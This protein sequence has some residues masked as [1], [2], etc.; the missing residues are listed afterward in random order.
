MNVPVIYYSAHRPEVRPESQW[1]VALLRHLLTHPEHGPLQRWNF[2]EFIEGPRQCGTVG[3]IVV[4]SGQHHHA[5]ADVAQLRLDLSNMKWAIVIIAGDECSLFPADAFDAL[6]HVVEWRM[7]PRTDI[8]YRPG[9]RFLEEGWPTG[10]MERLAV[11][12]RDEGEDRDLD[13]F[14]SGQ[15]THERRRELVLALESIVASEDYSIGGVEHYSTPGF[16]RGM[17]R[18][19]YLDHLLTTKIAPCPSGVCT[20]DSFRLYEAL[21]AGCLPVVETARPNGAADRDYWNKMLG[22][23]PDH[24]PFPGVDS[25]HELRDVAESSLASWP[26]RANKAGSWWFQRKREIAANLAD[27]LLRFTRPTVDDVN[28]QITVLIPT[29]PSPLH[30][31]TEIIRR[32][33]DSVRDQLP[34]AEV[35]VVIDGV[36]PEYEHMRQPYEEYQERLLNLCRDRWEGVTPIRFDVH[37]H[38]AAM[39]LRALEVVRTPLIFF[40]EHDWVLEPMEPVDEAGPIPWEGLAEDLIDNYTDVI[41][42]SWETEIEPTHLHLYRP[43]EETNGGVPLRPTQQWSQRPHLARA[44]Y[45]RRIL[46]GLGRSRTMIEDF[47][48]GVVSTAWR[49][50]TNAEAWSEHR[51]ALYHPEGSISRIRHT[52]GRRGGPVVEAEYHYD[53]PPLDGAPAETRTE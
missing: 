3:G 23:D 28:H 19:A 34:T 37:T 20:Q 53:G 44:D 50:K 45:Y 41:R 40:M 14:F 13:I 15:V 24:S 17:K 2:E 25:W 27:D 39:T 16:T 32:A 47:M 11:L 6:D 51:L 10:T 36:P 42:L 49:R 18:D 1:D 9:T 4:V 5:P 46:A 26:T 12:R 43:V 8:E 21:E 35:L 31:D 7:T 33:I 22:I 38:Q 29:S 52:D 48:H 30:P